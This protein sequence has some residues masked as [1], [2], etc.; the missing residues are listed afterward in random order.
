MA[1][2][3][4][5][6]TE[7]VLAAEQDERRR[8]ALFL[9]DGPVQS[10]AGVA[11]MLDASLD[12][13]ERGD[14]DEARSIIDRALERTR[15]TVGEL[16]DLSF[17]LEPVVLRDHGVAA[18]LDAL[19]E[20]RAREHGIEL[21][22]DIAAVDELGEREQ[23]ALYQI[24]R[25]ALEEA[26]RRG[27]PSRF[28]MSATADADALHLVIRDDAPSERRRRAL[29]VLAERARTLGAAL[30]VENEDAGTTMI[31]ELPLRRASE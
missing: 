18:A 26:I 16:R 11:L 23:A 10:L 7:Q 2:T 27:P 30:A 6:E 20:S 14:L 8:I 13:I 15:S 9:H 17:N 22:F 4:H 29:E 19:G 12:L 1:D 21:S 3:D 5:R 24:A 28:E 31:L 25:E